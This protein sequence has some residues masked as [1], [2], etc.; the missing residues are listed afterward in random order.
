MFLSQVTKKLHNLLLN[1][2]VFIAAPLF[3]LLYFNGDGYYIMFSYTYAQYDTNV[4]GFGG[5]CSNG[6]MMM[7]K[8]VRLEVMILIDG[9]F[10]LAWLVKCSYE[11][12]KI[13]DN[14]T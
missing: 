2:I 8:T 14:S 9:H 7:E 4:M 3:W 11:T 13:L 1:P 10:L 12:H 5:L 6:K